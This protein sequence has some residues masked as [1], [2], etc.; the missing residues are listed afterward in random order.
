MA[1]VIRTSS[2]ADSDPSASPFTCA[3]AIYLPIVLSSYLL[4]SS[5]INRNRVRNFTP[6]HIIVNLRQYLS[7]VAALQASSI[8][9]VGSLPSW[10]DHASTVAGGSHGTAGSLWPRRRG[11]V[12]RGPLVDRLMRCTRSHEEERLFGRRLRS[13]KLEVAHVLLVVL[14]TKRSPKLAFQPLQRVA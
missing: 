14:S 7:Q 8:R 10:T 13:L 3:R 2:I 5:S 12:G 1:V 9:T 6:L 4:C 11:P